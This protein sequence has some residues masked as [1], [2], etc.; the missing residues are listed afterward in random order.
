MQFGILGPLEVTTECGDAVALGGARA[1]ALLAVLLL[2]ANEPVSAERLAVALWGDDAPPGAIKTVQVHMSRL[3]KA[4]GDGATVETTPA[5][6]RLRVLPGELDA[7]RS[8]SWSTWGGGRS[9]M[10]SRSSRRRC[11]AR[12]LGCGVVRRCRISGTSRSWR[13][14]RGGSRSVSWPRWS[15]RSRAI[16]PPGVTAIAQRAT[17]RW[18]L[19]ATGTTRARVRSYDGRNQV[20][21]S[22]SL[23]GGLLGR[24]SDTYR[25]RRAR[26]STGWNSRNRGMPPAGLRA[27]VGPSPS[28]DDG[29][30]KVHL[31]PKRFGLLERWLQ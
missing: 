14:R 16:W 5:G 17:G 6:Y 25:L 27:R 31:H 12:P 7:E 15:W 3:R 18:G 4:L 10:E 2:H 9:P 11:C 29:V 20:G 30:D 8:T 23:P 28:G 26:F 22:W 19:Q 13:R 24:Q 1:R 21:F